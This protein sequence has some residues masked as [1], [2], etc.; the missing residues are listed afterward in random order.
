MQVDRSGSVTWYESPTSTEDRMIYLKQATGVYN[1]A[2]NLVRKMLFRFRNLRRKDREIPEDMEEYRYFAQA[3]EVIP[4]L[5]I[6]QEEI[7]RAQTVRVPTRPVRPTRTPQNQKDS[8]NDDYI[9]LFR[10]DRACG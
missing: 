7:T 9:P 1:D 4:F 8:N 5:G 10:Q 6:T 2:P 3:T